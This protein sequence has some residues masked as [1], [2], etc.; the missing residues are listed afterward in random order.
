MLMLDACNRFF[1]TLLDLVA[2]YKSGNEK[3]D[4]VNV[5]MDDECVVLLHFIFADIFGIKSKRAS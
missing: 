4:N 2:K 3:F 5:I 1:N